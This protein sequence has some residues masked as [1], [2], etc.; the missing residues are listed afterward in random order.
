M[1]HHSVEEL[2]TDNVNGE[3]Q[4]RRS[5]QKFRHVYTRKLPHSHVGRDAHQT[6]KRRARLSFSISTAAFAS[7][8]KILVHP[9]A[10]PSWT[11]VINEF[12]VKSHT[13]L[14]H[15]VHDQFLIITIIWMILFVQCELFQSYNR[16]SGEHK[17]NSSVKSFLRKR[18]IYAKTVKSIFMFFQEK[19][20]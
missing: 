4:R 19:K 10:D 12:I 2:V 7:S 6:P 17:S 16:H 15:L 1:T 13:L 9:S 3:K 14:V 5:P 11:S 18:I 8:W 20:F